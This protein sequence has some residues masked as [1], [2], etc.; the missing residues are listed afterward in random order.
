MCVSPSVSPLINMQIQL[1]YF[2]VDKWLWPLQIPFGWLC[3]NQAVKP[4]IGF[5]SLSH[6]RAQK[7]R[8]SLTHRISESFASRISPTV[9]TNNRLIRNL[10]S[11]GHCI[12]SKSAHQSCASPCDAIA[13]IH[14]P[15]RFNMDQRKR[16]RCHRKFRIIRDVCWDAFREMETRDYFRPWH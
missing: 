4:K 16:S 8:F 10:T 1:S 12:E 15:R 11:A 2:P 6:P 3:L 5:V 13:L 7:I 14:R 9:D